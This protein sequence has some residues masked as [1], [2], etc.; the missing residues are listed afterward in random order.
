M[1]QV[2]ENV[3]VS[4][5]LPISQPPEQHLLDFSN[6]PENYTLLQNTQEVGR[7]GTG[8]I[9]VVTL[10]SSTCDL[11]FH[12]RESDCWFCSISSSGKLLAQ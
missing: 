11:L 6:H 10:V 12:C 8:Q 5:F 1:D 3:R 2:L 7:S 9:M 4:S